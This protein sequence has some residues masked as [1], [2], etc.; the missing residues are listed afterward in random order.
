MCSQVMCSTSKPCTF[1]SSPCPEGRFVWEWFWPPFIEDI[2]S[3]KQFLRIF[4][5]YWIRHFDYYSFH[6]RKR[7]SGPSSRSFNAETACG[8]KISAKNRL[9][10][11][12]D[13][14]LGFFLGYVSFHGS[15]KQICS[16]NVKY[17]FVKFLSTQKTFRK[18]AFERQ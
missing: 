2:Q 5:P 3:I 1:S 8:N 11:I 12:S 4:T 13:A 9:L 10:E 14:I 17:M 15:F 6:T 18:R 16:F 7:T